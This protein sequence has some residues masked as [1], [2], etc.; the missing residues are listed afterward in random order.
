[1]AGHAL[2]HFA[3]RAIARRLRVDVAVTST[4]RQTRPERAPSRRPHDGQSDPSHQQ[5]EHDG[6]PPLWACFSNRP[7]VLRKLGA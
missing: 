2:A 4:A 7:L 1:M 6:V 3:R 5:S